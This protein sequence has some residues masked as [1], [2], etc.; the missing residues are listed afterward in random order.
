MNC[1]HLIIPHIKYEAVAQ[2]PRDAEKKIIWQAHILQIILVSFTK[3]VPYFYQHRYLNYEDRQGEGCDSLHHRVLQSRHHV[4]RA[5]HDPLS[6]V[7]GRGIFSTR[8][9]DNIPTSFP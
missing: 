8:K 6:D 3:I 2:K 4:L 7:I 9:I 1:V 5:T